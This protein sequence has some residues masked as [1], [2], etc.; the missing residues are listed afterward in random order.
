MKVLI[1][2]E[3][4]GTVRRA[5]RERGHDAW[6]ADILPADDHDKFHIEGDVTELLKPQYRWD[7]MIGHPPCTR[8]AN[9]GVSWLHRRNL[10]DDLDRACEF[11]LALWSA[12]IPRI[13]LENPIMHKHARQRICVDYAQIVQPW[14][15]GHPESKATCLWLK[16]LPKLK[17]TNNVKHI[18]DTLPD[19]ERQ[20]LHYLPPSKDRWKERSKTFDGIAKAMASQW[21]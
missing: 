19:N 17:E 3:S 20:R 8:L 6:S 1:A 5:F 2:C 12:P 9:S 14:Q 16:G 18:F 10:W 7:L 11:F 15:F 13:A 4:S 21:G